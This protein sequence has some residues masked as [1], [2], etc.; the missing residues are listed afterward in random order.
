MVGIDVL[1]CNCNSYKFIKSLSAQQSLKVQLIALTTESSN[2]QFSATDLAKL[3]PFD[4]CCFWLA[5]EY[6][7][8]ALANKYRDTSG[9]KHNF[10]TNS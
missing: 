1:F 10:S 7:N 8:R 4:S 2:E 6:D 5:Y 3:R 9:F